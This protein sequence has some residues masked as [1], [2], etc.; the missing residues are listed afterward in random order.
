MLSIEEN[1]HKIIWF[2]SDDML[3]NVINFNFLM[4]DLLSLE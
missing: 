1:G 4:I 2:W 3:Y